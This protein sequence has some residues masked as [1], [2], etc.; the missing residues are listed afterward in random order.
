MSECASTE[1]SL[2]NASLSGEISFPKE[3][4]AKLRGYFRQGHTRSYAFR[5]R[6]LDRLEQVVRQHEKDILSALAKDL[7]KPQSEAYTS[8]LAIFYHEVS[9]VKKHLA[10]WMKPNKVP[11]PISAGL[12]KSYL[13]YEPYGVSLIFSPWNFPFNLSFLPLVGAI[14]AGNCAVV[15]PSE[16]TPNCS[17]LIQTIINSAFDEDY[18]CCVL[19]GPES[20]SELLE[21]R[22]DHIFFTGS[23]AVGK[24]VAQSAA[25]FLT[26]ITLELGGKSPCY[27]RGD[28]DL[29]IA[30]RRILFG[31]AINAGQVCVAPDFVMIDESV[32]DRFL[33]LLKLELIRMFGE[34]PVTSPDYGRIVNEKQFKRLVSYIEHNREYVAHGGDYDESKR[35]IAP[36][37]L[38]KVPLDHPVLKEE[39]FGPILPLI[40]VKDQ[41]QAMDIVQGFEK[42]L[43]CYMFTSDKH[44]AAR[45]FEHISFGGGCIN[46]TIMH[47]TNPNLPFG[48]VGQSGAGAYHGKFSFEEFSHR[49]SVMDTATWFDPPLRYLPSRPWKDKLVRLVLG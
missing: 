7:G 6:Q 13:V 44:E 32:Y 36:T 11:T 41:S 38:S 34:Y 4:A 5:I 21:Q 45:F 15:K 28:A 46:D 49:K 42:P 40:P 24:I 31:K 18:I 23:T 14:A 39:I 19:G 33:S 12:A 25:K 37:L 3:I 26:P 35:F 16:Y 9:Y 43:A 2:E 29:D 48:G 10:R 30:A 27:V 8:E 22:W 47:M 1:Q 17:A 20:A